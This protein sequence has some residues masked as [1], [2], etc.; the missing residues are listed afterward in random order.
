MIRSLT[1][2]KPSG[3][4]SSSRRTD[5]FFNKDSKRFCQMISIG[6][7]P[8]ESSVSLGAYFRWHCLRGPRDWTTM[9]RS[10]RPRWG[11]IWPA[12]ALCRTHWSCSLKKSRARWNVPSP[13]MGADSMFLLLWF[14]SP[15]LG[16]MGYRLS[17]WPHAQWKVILV[18]DSNTFLPVLCHGVGICFFTI[19]GGN[20]LH[21]RGLSV[22]LFFLFLW[23]LF[24]FIYSFFF[25]IL[26]VILFH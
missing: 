20:A 25:Q 8:V 15:L 11:Y 21:Q 24:F 7:N 22:L 6:E 3:K 26:F 5:E 23:I 16:W 4:W 1:S 10:K 17:Q 14:S 19:N 9:L 18:F 13:K 12:Q 2:C